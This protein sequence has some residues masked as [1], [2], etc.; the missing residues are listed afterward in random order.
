MAL[1]NSSREPNERATA[2][3]AH[4]ENSSQDA[5]AHNDGSVGETRNERAEKLADFLQPNARRG[6]SNVVWTWTLGLLNAPP[7]A[8]S[9]VRIG[10][11][12]CAKGIMT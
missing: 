7:A 5:A 3:S 11:P 4:I 1:S 8:T 12:Y 10:D 9:S 2:I 6:T